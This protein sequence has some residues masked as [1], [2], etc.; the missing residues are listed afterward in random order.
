MIFNSFLE[1]INSEED[2]KQYRK[3]LVIMGYS[4]EDAAEIVEKRR[5]Q[6][7]LKNMKV[8]QA[9]VEAAYLKEDSN[10]W[11]SLESMIISSDSNLA[12]VPPYHRYVI[13]TINDTSFTEAS[14]TL[15]IP[16]NSLWRW[17]REHNYFLRGMK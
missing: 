12:D 8:E 11:S 5:H 15:G 6:L 1:D 9:A 7:R 4:E 13:A 10:G 14:K 2:Y 16:R 17:L 3:M